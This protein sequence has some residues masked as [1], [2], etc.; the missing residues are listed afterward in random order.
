MPRLA[1]DNAANSLLERT[2]DDSANRR[3]VLPEAFLICDELL[4]T[5]KRILSGL[6]VNETAIQRNLEV[7]APFAAVERVLMALVKAGADRQVMHEY[8]REH[9]MTAWGA[10]QSGNPNPL[11]ELISHDPEITLLSACR[12]SNSADGC[13]TITWGMHLSV[14][15][16]WQITIRRMRTDYPNQKQNYPGIG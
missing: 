4:M 8:L 14:P 13:L 12:S 9:S 2:L 10:I 11:A 15:G 5:A 16:R 7:Y 1:W 6:Q 3:V